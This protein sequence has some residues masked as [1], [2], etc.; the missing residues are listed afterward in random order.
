MQV[1][2]VAPEHLTRLRNVWG[3]IWFTYVL[4]SLKGSKTSV[5]SDPFF[6]F[7]CLWCYF[8]VSPTSR[9]AR[10]QM[11]CSE[12]IQ[13]SKAVGD[14]NTWLK[15]QCDAVRRRDC[16]TW[17][18]TVGRAGQ[19]GKGETKISLCCVLWLFYHFYDCCCRC[20]S[21]SF[22]FIG[23]HT[24][25][26]VVGIDYN[27]NNAGLYNVGRVALFPKYT[28]RRSVFPMN[29][30]AFYQLL[31][32]EGRGRGRSRRRRR[33]TLR[34]ALPRPVQTGW[35]TLLMTLTLFL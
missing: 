19:P 26:N 7:D 9:G 24:G 32:S 11:L 6:K 30:R 35:I 25:R 4:L 29:G 3:K 27:A 16:S 28:E 21:P 17:P 18:V 12:M 33:S 31:R 10:S 13:Q 20:W 1:L 15:N 5:E 14:H 8:K 34:A 22:F 23:E 2:G